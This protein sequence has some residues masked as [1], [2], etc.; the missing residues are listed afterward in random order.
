[1]GK[2]KQ[3]YKYLLQLLGAT[4]LKSAARI[5]A[6]HHGRE[7]NARTL[8]PLTDDEM[9]YVESLQN[10]EKVASGLDID[11][12]KAVREKFNLTSRKVGLPTM[13]G[14]RP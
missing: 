12:S 2:F 5:V 6:E 9:R 11:L 3:R 10:P 14:E 7:I 4:G 8:R 1:M 13:I